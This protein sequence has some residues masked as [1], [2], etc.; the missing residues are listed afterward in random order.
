MKRIGALIAAGIV[1][2]ATP[3][4]AQTVGTCPRGGGSTQPQPVR[5]LFDLN[6]SHLRPAEKPIIAQAVKTAKDRQVSAVCL[7]GHTDKLGD[8]AYNLKLA[9]AR[10]QT[11]AAE[12]IRDG[13][14]AKNIT[15]VADPEA[16][17]NMSF[18]NDN[19]SEID[20]KVTIF[21]AR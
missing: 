14:P 3:S 5:I 12:M 16:F 15:I 18:G 11:V 19:A 2:A 6:S 10:A 17:G 20:R 21:Y 9:R 4:F 8:K 1:L 13:Y 7:I